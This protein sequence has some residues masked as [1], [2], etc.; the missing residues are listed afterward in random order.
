[1]HIAPINREPTMSHQTLTLSE[2][3]ERVQ[4]RTEKLEELNRKSAFSTPPSWKVR[5]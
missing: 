2:L 5:R 4:Q 3:E 1:M